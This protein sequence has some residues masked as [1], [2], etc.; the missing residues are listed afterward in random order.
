MNTLDDSP[1]PGWL[2][3]FL[4]GLLVLVAVILFARLG[5]LQ[6]IKGDYYRTLSDDNRI[7]RIPILAPR[8]QILGSDG[9]PIVGNTPIQEK[10]I[11]TTNGFEKSLDT[12]D[13]SAINSITESKR[14]Y[15]LGP[16]AAHLTGYLSEVDADEVNKVDPNCPDKGP[17]IT[18][19]Y[20]GVSG[21]E[22]EYDCT[23]RGID[24]EELIEVDAAGNPVRVLGIKNPVP[25]SDIKTTI[26]VG[27]QQKVADTVNNLKI[28]TSEGENLPV[29]RKGS[30]VITNGQGA[31][32][33]MYSFPSFDPNDFINS[34][35]KKLSSYFTDPNLPLF[36]RSLDGLYHPGSTFKIV[37]ST[38]ALEENK[39]DTNFTY[40][41]VGYVELNGYKYDNWYWDEYGK[42]EG[43][44]NI[45]RA[46]ARST[47]TFFYKVGEMV[48]IDDL[49]SWA[50]KFGLDK[51]SGIDL[52][53]EATG[54]IPSPAW[55]RQFNGEKWFLGDTYNVSIGQ[56]DVNLTPVA[57]NILASVVAND[58]QICKPYVNASV[59]KSCY[60][61]NL[62]PNTL[63]TIKEGM[64]DACSTGG[65]GFP[66]FPWN[67]PDV[68]GSAQVS[69]PQVTVACKTGT[70]ETGDQNLTHAWFAAF[71]PADNPK[72]VID[73]IVEKAGQGSEVAAPIAKEILG[74]YFGKK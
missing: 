7:R 24:G 50:K 11:F 45:V 41:D 25:G 3:W 35:S 16:D 19:S 67:S 57:S 42:T 63:S 70:A 65:T 28:N 8:G 46:I 18:N 30:I 27:L 32:L 4:K 58:G 43:P 17:R 49:S 26:N 15:Y 54:I 39:I 2:S 20:V 47:D 21:L 74:Y 36:N 33:A 56:G 44:I 59:G 48:G 60:S 23:L 64:I 38:A 73:V 5:E 51:P 34:N 66:F 12:T 53:N 9:T 69:G 22:Q 71:A 31:V 72:I 14:D 40:D 10:I 6:I 52:P 37:T 61:L 68:T 1:N 62:N 55:K 13:T 29:G